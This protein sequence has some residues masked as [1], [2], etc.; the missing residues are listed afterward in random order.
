[1]QLKHPFRRQIYAGRS[2]VELFYIASRRGI[3][4]RNP[5]PLVPCEPQVENQSVVRDLW[6]MFTDLAGPFAATG[7]GRCA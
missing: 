7:A 1:M 5:D 3:P 2:D 6:R 4:I